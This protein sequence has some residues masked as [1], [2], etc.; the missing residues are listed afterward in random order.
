VITVLIYFNEE[1]PHPGGRL[2]ILRS[3]TDLDDYADE[4][5]PLAGTMVAF[6]RGER[7]FHG[8]LPHAG[9]RRMVQVHWV[10]AK[11]VERNQRKRRSFIWRAKKLLRLE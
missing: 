6:R 10:D 1:W 2:R 4:V 7:S 8:H 11:R 9:H 3:A 5:S